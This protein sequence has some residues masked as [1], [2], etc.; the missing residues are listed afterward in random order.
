M[1]I[2][3]LDR[4]PVIQVVNEITGETIYTLRIRDFSY[5]PG[6]FA[7][8]SYMVNI[9]EPGTGSIKILKGL[10]SLPTKDQ[11]RITVTF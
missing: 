4:P 10:F 3:G 2:A 8:G 11:D 1:R 5:Q 6:V 9:G 7:E